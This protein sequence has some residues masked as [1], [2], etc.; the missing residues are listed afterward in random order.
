MDAL[1]QVRKD[2]WRAAYAKAS[3]LAKEAPKK[4]GRVRS[5]DRAAQKAL[6]A[7]KEAS[8]IKKSTYALGKAP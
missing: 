8:E 7:R 4:R 5:D 2:R 6:A 3:E 1:D